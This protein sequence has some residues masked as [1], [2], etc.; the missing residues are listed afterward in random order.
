MRMMPADCPHSLRVRWEILELPFGAE[1]CPRTAPGGRRPGCPVPRFPPSVAGPVALAPVYGCPIRTGRLRPAHGPP[2]TLPARLVPARPGRAGRR[3][4]RRVGHQRRPERG[5]GRQPRRCEPRQRDQPEPVRPVIPR[6]VLRLW[7]AVQPRTAPAGR[8]PAMHR[9]GRR[10]VGHCDRWQTVTVHESHSP[11]PWRILALQVPPTPG[12]GTPRMTDQPRQPDHTP[13][14][15][16]RIP[17]DLLSR[18]RQSPEAA[19]ASLSLLER[20]G[21]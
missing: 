11:R 7:L 10:R 1:R 20:A 5:P 9:P 3:Q 16:V 4:P 13:T 14:R 21:Q 8:Q 12:R 15:P 19:D 2:W 6:V 17:D 18:A